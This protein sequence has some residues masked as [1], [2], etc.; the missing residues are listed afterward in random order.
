MCAY[1]VVQLV[2]AHGSAD[3]LE[4]TGE[5]EVGDAAIAVEVEVVEDALPEALVHL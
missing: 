4:Q 1:E 3:A 5:F 2:V